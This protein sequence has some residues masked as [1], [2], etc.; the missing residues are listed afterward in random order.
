M[1][2]WYLVS[3]LIFAAFLAL[4]VYLDRKNWK[5]ESVLLLR[6]TQ[7]GKAFL[8]WLG[9]RFPRFWLVVGTFAVII[10]FLSSI[11][12]VWMLFALLN[13]QLSGQIG[14]ALGFALPSPSSQASA[15]PGYLAIPF[16]YW[17]ISIATLVIVHEGMHGVMSAREK[18]KIKSLGI[19]LL[20]V[21]PLAFVEPD[22]KQLQKQKPW[23]QLRVFA[24][25][26]FANYVTTVFFI[27]VLI[28]FSSLVSPMFSGVGVGYQALAQGYPAANA[29][30]TG[31]ITGIDNY[32]ILN[33][34]DLSHALRAIGPNQTITVRTNNGTQDFTY[35]LMTAPEPEPAFTP[36]WTTG[37]A[38][39]IEQVVPGSI[40]FTSSVS[41]GFSQL[42]GG[43]QQPTWSSLQK[44][45]KFWQYTKA[46]HPSLSAEADSHIASL[47]SQFASHP[48]S[49]F[50]GILGV[51][52]V[53]KAA[54]G[55]E[56][57]QESIIFITELLVF[58][59]LINFGV[60][61][62]NMLPIGPL[63]GGRMWAIIVARISKKHSK[64]IMNVIT[65][66]VLGLVATIFAVPFLL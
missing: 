37:I 22:E 50:I 27:G 2:D 18:V 49:G 45:I 21:I 5:R 17:I 7:K 11:Y 36:D 12:M 16:W 41:N 47:E 35:T 38:L 14:T 54:P 13:M 62:F 63:D 65:F 28:V 44:E 29:N 51:Q 48:R 10:T 9:T 20:A 23:K 3:V 26:S 58:L 46:S 56:G 57:Y 42:A 19:G 34:T 25:G 32:V 59:V 4:F 8:I 6:K 55:T 40:D 60:G 52:N 31:T 24:A 64:T 33:S 61:L 53:T 43:Y 15:G 39:G 66:L 30:M 1:V